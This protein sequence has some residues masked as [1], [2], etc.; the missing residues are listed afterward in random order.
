MGTEYEYTESNSSK[1]DR[2]ET[3]QES[4]QSVEKFGKLKRFLYECK[5]VLRVTKKPTKDE[6]KSIVKVSGIGILV[7]GLIGFLLQMIKQLL[8]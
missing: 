7:I 1:E 2:D 4:V 5:I 8:F 6:F 3:T